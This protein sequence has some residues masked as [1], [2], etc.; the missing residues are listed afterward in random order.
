M[1]LMGGEV[2]EMPVDR[3]ERESYDIGRDIG[4]KAIVELW[5][6]IAQED[7]SILLIERF[8]LTE[9]KSKEYI[10]K[11]WKDN[12]K[13]ATEGK[14]FWDM[15]KEEQEQEIRAFIEEG[16]EFEIP[17]DDVRTKLGEK[18]YLTGDE[19]FKYMFKYWV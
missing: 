4:I 16:Q 7:L 15:S 5:Q 19:V 10:S 6:Q 2:L 8:N 1:T 18:F 17:K 3:V 13:D 12:I 11:F 14:L 9:A